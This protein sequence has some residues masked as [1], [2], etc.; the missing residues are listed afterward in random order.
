MLSGIKILEVR[1]EGLAVAQDSSQREGVK[2]LIEKAF[3]GTSAGL[4]EDL[5][6]RYGFER[7]ETEQGTAIHFIVNSNVGA[8]QCLYLLEPIAETL[9]EKYPAGQFGD[10]ATSILIWILNN[11]PLATQIGM[12]NT[13]DGARLTMLE[14]FE[15]IASVTPELAGKVNPGALRGRRVEA[16]RTMN[17]QNTLLIDP[18]KSGPLTEVS[19]ERLSAAVG[20]ILAEGTS[21]EQITAMGLASRLGCEENS[22][23]KALKRRGE[24]LKSFL[25]RFAGVDN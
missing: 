18:P 1:V 19:I 4:L 5:E 12:E 8:M 14:T 2:T 13:Y 3:A 9:L 20:R 7:L 17:D 6:T 22:I 24:T 10:A 23:H 25:A 21:L 11:L 15:A 16:L